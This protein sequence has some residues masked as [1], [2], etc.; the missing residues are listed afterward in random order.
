MY[1]ID[2]TRVVTL[3]L[4]LGVALQGMAAPAVQ[5][6]LANAGYVPA[7]YTVATAWKEAPKADGRLVYGVRLNPVSGDAAFDLYYGEDGVTLNDDAQKAAGIVPKNWQWRSV[8]TPGEKVASPAKRGPRPLPA[9]KSIGVSKEVM[10]LDAPDVPAALREDALG[11]STPAK[12]V[13]RTGVFQD[14]AIPVQVFEG[15]A[16][17]GAWSTTD[18]GGKVWALT[19]DAPGAVGLRLHCSRMPLPPGARV[20]VY[21]ANDPAEVYGPFPAK[22]DTWTPTCFSE[23]VTIEC[24]LPANANPGAETLLLEIDR[25]VYQ[26]RSLDSLMLKEGACHLDVTC[27]P[28]WSREAGAV[29]G[30]GTIGQ[31]G[32][33]WCTG[34]LLADAVPGTAIPYFLTADH[35]VSTPSAAMNLEIYWMYNT[36][37]CDSGTPPDPA[38]VPRTTGGAQYLLS[39]P[40]SAGTDVSFMRLN[41]DPPEEGEA[42]FAGYSTAAWPIDTPVTCIHHPQGTYKRI[43]FGMTTNT[44]SPSNNNAHIMGPLD[45]FYEVLW[46][47]EGE[48][49]TTEP[50]SSG[51]AL[52]AFEG[53][54]PLVIGQLYGGLA[55][56]SAKNEPDSFGRFN[57]SYA[58]LEP[59][60]T[61]N[62]IPAELTVTFENTDSGSIVMVTGT[63]NAETV[64]EPAY[65]VTSGTP[66][67][68][69]AIPFTGY[70]FQGWSINGASSLLTDNPL[71]LTVTANVSVAAV[72]TGQQFSLEVNVSGGGHITDGDGNTMTEGTPVLIDAQAEI[73]LTPQADTG[74][75]FDHWSV[76]GYT[77]VFTDNPLEFL[78][79][80]NY[81]FT[82]VFIEDNLSGCGSGPAH[83]GTHGADAGLMFAMLAALWVLR[84][85]AL[86]RE[87]H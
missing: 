15:Q 46:N 28:Q 67:S 85:R 71:D 49:G 68:L 78:M 62:N 34:T 77:E 16:S 23:A 6:V 38:F 11:L 55:S 1:F 29:G 24:Y 43:S 81:V 42:F 54:A 31:D 35:C 79:N 3:I 86:T 82:A 9:P 12:G 2:R 75:T 64:F 56:C 20:C 7:D 57:R 47:S 40:A 58:L 39:S 41:N 22:D 65:T 84:R 44:G 70:V 13:L 4:S 5:D 61:G 19:L 36:E 8:T 17:L 30:I 50:G 37:V 18:D 59:W 33:L 14:L 48:G 69:G 51:S 27:F 83:P 80:D 52:F 45:R 10:A 76:E 53:E 73:S 72:F 74:Y 87:E 63:G 21:D 66:L 25:T 32:S 60:L 26:Y